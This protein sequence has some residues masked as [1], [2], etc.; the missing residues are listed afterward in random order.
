MK[1]FKICFGNSVRLTAERLEHIRLHPEMR[2]LEAT[3][4]VVLQAPEM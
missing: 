1:L 4:G 2:D 3:I